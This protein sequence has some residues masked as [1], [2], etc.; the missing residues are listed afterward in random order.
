[1]KIGN[2]SPERPSLKHIIEDENPVLSIFLRGHLVLEALLFQ[3]IQTTKKMSDKKI[4]KMSCSEK[5]EYCYSEKLFTSQLKL[6][7][8][9][10]NLLR[11][12][13]SHRLG[14]NLTKRD[15][16]LLIRLAGESPEVDFSDDMHTL[17]SKTLYEWYG[18]TAG[19]LC[20]MFKHVAMDISFLVEGNGG[21][22]MFAN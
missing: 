9:Q 6:F 11:N 20:E 3:L 12:K 2:Y 22:F 17:D 7:L 15:V 19:V 8:L 18:D 16:H 5:I 13:F 1:M 21:E 4:G 10:V 14:Y